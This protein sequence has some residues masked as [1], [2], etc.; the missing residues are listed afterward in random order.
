MLCPNCK[1]IID[2]DSRFCRFCGA[3]FI[4]DDSEFEII[5]EEFDESGDENEAF[6]DYI[7]IPEDES[8]AVNEA[9]RRKNPLTPK[10]I[11]V[12]VILCVIVGVMLA[13]GFSTGTIGPGR[14]VITD[15]AGEEIKTGRGTVELTVR[16]V[17]GTTRT[18]LS[19][20]SLI[21]PEQILEE[22]A[23]VMNS[24]KA[25]APAFS[26]TRYQNLPSDKQNLGAVAS[27]VL[28]IIEKYVTSKAAA[29]PEAFHAGNANQLPVKDSS[30]GCLLKD[31]S[32]IKNAYCEI[33]DDDTYKLVLTFVDE[34]NPARL[35]AGAEASSGIINAV[36]DPYDAAEQIT[37]ISSLVMN[38]INFNY[39][40]CTVTLVYNNDT[41]L[42]DSVNMTMNID[43][44]A[45][46]I[47]MQINA[48]IVDI[49]EFTNFV[50]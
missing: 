39:T 21:T 3:E 22:Y 35:S 8:E 42:V 15:A 29:E 14:E 48:R 18:V 9:K 16:D 4:D 33:L 2:D 23:S 11:A 17:D 46:T 50:Y 25:D 40:D 20:K 10:L 34:M 30:Y 47:L 12:I 49:T 31:A 44:T 27:A 36:F 1:N 19:D 24:L 13:V 41:K 7:V 45:D 43:I 37:A 28:P 5:P 6:T 38:D 32:A 26:K